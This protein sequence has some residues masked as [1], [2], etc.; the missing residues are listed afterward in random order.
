MCKWLNQRLPAALL[1]AAVPWALPSTTLAEEWEE[2]S[3]YYEDDAWYDIT[4]WLD[5]NDY[6]PT[7]ESAGVWNDEVYDSAAVESDVDSDWF[8][9]DRQDETDNWYYDYYDDDYAYYDYGDDD[10]MYEYSYSYYDYDDDAYYDAFSSSY[11]SDDDGFFDSYSYVTFDTA[12]DS[13]NAEQTKQQVSQQGKAGAAKQSSVS[14]KVEKTKTVK[15]RSGDRLVAQVTSDQG[16]AVVVDLGPKGQGGEQSATPMVKQGQQISAK[17]PMIKVGDKQVLLA[18]TVKVAD[19]QEQQVSRS[20]RQI[21]GKV[22]KVKTARIRG[23][24]HQMAIVDLAAGKQI[25]VDLGRA[26]KLQVEIKEGDQLDISGVPVKV[27]DKA[28][29]I[30]NSVTKGGEKVKIERTARKD[31]A[32][33]SS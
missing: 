15:V 20:G 28:V 22:A 10:G 33:A 17:G 11:D 9:Y 21:S 5:G 25:L 27:N 18:Q 14:G 12:A 23:Q 24:E 32:K 3:V 8:G 29:I 4:E 13:K 1:A 26:D 19:G 6:N 7:D 16:K 31:K 30:A 2:N